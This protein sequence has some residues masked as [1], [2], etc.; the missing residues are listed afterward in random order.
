VATVRPLAID[1]ATGGQ[2]DLGDVVGDVTSAPVW[3]PDGKQILFGARGGSLYSVDVQSGERSL[4]VRLPGE[5]LD[6]MDEIEW[7]PDGAHLAVVNDLD[8]PGGG[9]L[10]VMDADGSRVHVLVDFERG[11]NVVWSPDGTRLTYLDFSGSDKRELSIWTV[12]LDGST[13]SLVGSHTFR[14]CPI[15]GCDTVWSPDGSQIAFETFG[16]GDRSRF[17]INADGTG[18]ARPIDELAYLSWGDGSFF[19]ECYG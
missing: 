4:F 5:D 8:E 14:D 7:S 13:P 1:A 19:C 11:S 3:S 17:V 2:T 6:S 10:Y 18:S 12:S 9:R 15:D 16:T